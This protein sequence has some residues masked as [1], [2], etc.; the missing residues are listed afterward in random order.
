MRFFSNL[1]VF[2]FPLG[3]RSPSSPYTKTEGVNFEQTEAEKNQTQVINQISDEYHGTTA[4][5]RRSHTRGQH[6]AQNTKPSL[7]MVKPSA[8]QIYIETE[9]TIVP[10]LLRTSIIHQNN[11][12]LISHQLIAII[13]SIN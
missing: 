2:L 7:S 13:M 12:Y 4:K 6:T 11:Q 5:R 8:I 10:V 3:R 9:A 1:L